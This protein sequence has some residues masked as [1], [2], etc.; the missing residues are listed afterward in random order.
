MMPA[1]LA[2]MGPA[3]LFELTE[4]WLN[5]ERRADYRAGVIAASMVGGSPADFFA[6]LQPDP[7]TEEELELKLEKALGV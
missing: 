2:A 5:R 7:L 1:E 4:A 3:E 6:S